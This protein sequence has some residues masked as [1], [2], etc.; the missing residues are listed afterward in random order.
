MAICQCVIR[1]QYRLELGGGRELV[2][3]KQAVQ[4]GALHVIRFPRVVVVQF[5]N[6]TNR[7]RHQQTFVDLV[8]TG[9]VEL[10]E[11]KRDAFTVLVTVSCAL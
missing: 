10:A 7:S 11:S 9:E 1:H 3:V 6:G 5:G 8:V 4:K 2:R